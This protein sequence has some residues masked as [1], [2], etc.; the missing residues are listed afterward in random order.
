MT[1]VQSLT[2]FL[3]LGKA[4]CAMDAGQPRNDR[5]GFGVIAVTQITASIRV[6]N[7]IKL[8]LYC[9]ISCFVS[10]YRFKPEDL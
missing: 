7:I 8:K 2:W 6:L 9:I 5:P 10:F 3:A 4:M 1:R